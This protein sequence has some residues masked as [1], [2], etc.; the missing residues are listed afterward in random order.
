VVEPTFFVNG[1]RVLVGNPGS[2]KVRL[3]RVIEQELIAAGR[4][5]AAGTAPDEVYRTLVES[6][7]WGV[8]DDPSRRV[9]SA[10]TAEAPPAEAP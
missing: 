2:L 3:T 8:D 1:R 5:T 6:G 7:Y 4:L 9:Y 10:A